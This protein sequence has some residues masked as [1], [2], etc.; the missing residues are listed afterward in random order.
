[1]SG[2]PKFIFPL[3]V[4]YM[5]I[6]CVQYYPVNRFRIFPYEITSHVCILCEAIICLHIVNNRDASA[7]SGTRAYDLLCTVIQMTNARTLDTAYASRCFQYAS[8]LWPRI[9]YCMRRH[10][11]GGKCEIYSLILFDCGAEYTL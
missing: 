7:V 3:F 8:I 2:N 5:C 6:L 1:M 10:V 9:I 4:F 11:I